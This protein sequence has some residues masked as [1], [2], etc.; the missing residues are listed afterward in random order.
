MFST[1]KALAF[2]AALGIALIP[3]GATMAQAKPVL[4]D[5]SWKIGPG[6]GK[7][8]APWGCKGT[9]NKPNA[10][11]YPPGLGWSAKQVCAGDFGVQ[12]VCVYLQY[13]DYYGK[14]TNRSTR[15]CSRETVA[16]TMYWGDSDTCA[17]AG[18]GTYRTWGIGYAWPDGVQ[19][20][21][22]AYSDSVVLC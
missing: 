14:W 21:A 16:T 17:H 13:L 2:S 20:S 7:V 19:N 12:K 1:R 11:S 3:L 15:S 18:R 9:A 8:T 10:H 6:S 4:P 5:G 22:S